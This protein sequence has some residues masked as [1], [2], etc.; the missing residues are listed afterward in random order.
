MCILHCYHGC[1]NRV[2]NHFSQW[3]ICKRHTGSRFTESIECVFDIYTHTGPVVTTSS[4]LLVALI[5]LI[6]LWTYF[7]YRNSSTK[8]VLF[9][10][11][12]PVILAV[13]ISR[14]DSLCTHDHMSLVT[15]CV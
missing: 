7:A 14:S 12:L 11:W 13:L 15:V 1:P 6:P 4:C 3:Y 8:A 5:V 2:S 9:V 10:G